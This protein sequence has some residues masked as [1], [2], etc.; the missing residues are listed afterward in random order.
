MRP[1]HLTSLVTRRHVNLKPPTISPHL[2][3]HSPLTIEGLDTIR[4]LLDNVQA[5]DSDRTAPK[6]TPTAAVL[7]PLCNVNGEAGI[8]LEVRSGKL[9]THGGEVSFPGGKVDETDTSPAETAL[10]ET[11]EELGIVSEQVQIVGQMVTWQE[12]ALNGLEVLPYV[13][14]VSALNS[15]A[16]SSLSPLSTLKLESLSISRQEVAQV[17]HLPFREL[18]DPSRLRKR[19]FRDLQPYWAID[20]TDKVNTNIYRRPKVEDEI[21]GGRD[22]RLEV[23]GLQV[24]ICIC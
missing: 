16:T 4:S 23:W 22:G 10:R 1:S 15:G 19:M 2:Q 14:F 11:W 9:R 6:H 18:L 7:I 24:G 20:V 13:G 8:L 12:Q 5:A 21:D 17:F 3:L